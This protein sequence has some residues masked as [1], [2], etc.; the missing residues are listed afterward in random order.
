[1]SPLAAALAE[2]GIPPMDERPLDVRV[3]A[4]LARRRERRLRGRR[5]NHDPGDEDRR[6]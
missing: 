5:V 1:M 6:S 4:A 2:A 3:A